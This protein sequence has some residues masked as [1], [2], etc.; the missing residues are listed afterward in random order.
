LIVMAPVPLIEFEVSVAVM[1]WLPE[2][3]SVKATVC[4]PLSPATN[5]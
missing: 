4:V 2:V 5:V 1:A 3:T